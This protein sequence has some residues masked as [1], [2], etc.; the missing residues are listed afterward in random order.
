LESY[1]LIY[2]YKDMGIIQGIKENNKIILDLLLKTN[3]VNEVDIV[4][5]IL[6]MLMGFDTAF[7]KYNEYNGVDVSY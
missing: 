2:I 4:R 7:F 1:F 5:E 6:F 3:Y